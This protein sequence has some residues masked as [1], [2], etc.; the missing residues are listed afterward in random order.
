MMN[1][2]KSLNKGETNSTKDALKMFSSSQKKSRDMTA[3]EYDTLETS[4]PRRSHRPPQP[5]SEANPV[6]SREDS[7][8]V[9]LKIV[10]FRTFGGKQG[11][12]QQCQR[13]A[14]E[15]RHKRDK[16]TNGSNRITLLASLINE[17]GPSSSSKQEEE[18]QYR[19]SFNPSRIMEA[20]SELENS[21]SRRQGPYPKHPRLGGP[22]KTKM[23]QSRSGSNQNRPSNQG[24]VK[25]PSP[26]RGGKKG[27]SLSLRY[28]KSAI[29]SDTVSGYQLQG[30]SGR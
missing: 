15:Q 22:E 18:N 27:K 20:N 12:G 28:S 21:R 6:S 2:K 26:E 3:F 14:R 23:S 17:K 7:G 10:E 4:Q 1:S 13:R 29:S 19:L 24:F 8:L 16:A 11:R 30:R 25:K 9:D 5:G